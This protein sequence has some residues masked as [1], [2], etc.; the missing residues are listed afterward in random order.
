MPNQ[1]DRCF[2]YLRVRVGDDRE[3]ASIVHCHAPAAE[4]RRLTVRLRA[5]I[6][7]A[8]QEACAGDRFIWG[9]GFDTKFLQA[10]I[11]VR[12]ILDCYASQTG[13]AQPGKLQ[14]VISHPEK[15]EYYDFAM[16]HGLRAVETNSE[17]GVSFGGV[18]D[19]HDLVV[20]RVFGLGSSPP[21]Q[22][23]ADAPLP[24]SAAQP[25]T[26]S[27]AAN[28]VASTDGRC[29]PPAA[30]QNTEQLENLSDRR[31]AACTRNTAVHG[32]AG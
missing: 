30:P 12:S 24:R 13:A 8:C 32:R 4:K 10:T 26:S 22:K 7:L 3:P 19:A 25:A 16:T 6:F 28:I 2:Q 31:E 14:L 18:S 11:L 27:A 15:F 1:A 29:E 21:A 9:G 17:V 5:L 23:K 20:A